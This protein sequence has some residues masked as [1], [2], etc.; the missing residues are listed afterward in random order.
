MGSISFGLIDSSNKSIQAFFVSLLFRVLGGRRCCSLL[1]SS[2]P[3]LSFLP[4]ALCC[5][6]RQVS[7]HLVKFTLIPS[8]FNRS[9]VQILYLPYSVQPEWFQSLSCSLSSWFSSHSL[10]HLSNGVF[11]ISFIPGVSF[12][13]VF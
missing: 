11:S 4:E 3:I 10:F 12:L 13:Q 2:L 6:S 8:I 1:R 5:C 9:A 7:S